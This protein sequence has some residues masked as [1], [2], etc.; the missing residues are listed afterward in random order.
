M[1][2][3]EEVDQQEQTAQPST[4]A[5]DPQVQPENPEEQTAPVTEEVQGTDATAPEGTPITLEQ[6]TQL[7]DNQAYGAYANVDTVSLPNGTSFNFAHQ[8]TL[9]DLLIASGIFLLV[10]FLVLKWLLT[11]VW[12]RKV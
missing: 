8:V 11:S 10:A 12:E 2:E 1:I 4:D 3:N 6:L 5:P 7:L 9:G